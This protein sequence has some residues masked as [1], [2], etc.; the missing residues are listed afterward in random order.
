MD[1]AVEDADLEP[2]AARANA[3]LDAKGWRLTSSRTCAAR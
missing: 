3:L 2:Y 1:F